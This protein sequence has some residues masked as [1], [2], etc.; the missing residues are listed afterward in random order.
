MTDHSCIVRDDRSKT[1]IDFNGSSSKTIQDAPRS[2][3]PSWLA[4]W[5]IQ[6]CKVRNAL[7]VFWDTLWDL[8]EIA[9]NGC[10][11]LHIQ[12][13]EG[14]YAYSVRQKAEEDYG[15]PDPREVQH[16][17]AFLNFFLTSDSSVF[18]QRKVNSKTNVFWG[19]FRTNKIA[20]KTSG[21]C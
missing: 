14:E 17:P 5:K 19:N 11:C 9:S 15:R 1:A 18:F 4:A 2:V 6:F 12:N 21:E 20:T 16:T 3:Q 10:K 8:H 13:T 7:L